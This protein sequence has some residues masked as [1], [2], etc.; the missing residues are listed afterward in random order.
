[1]SNETTALVER[2]AS[3]YRL[4]TTVVPEHYEIKLTPDLEKFTFAG[5]ETVRIKVLEPI[6]EIV[7]NAAELDIKHA[8][9]SDGSGKKVEASVSYDEKRERALLKLTESVAA[10]QYK[11]HID[12]SGIL[13]DKLHGFYRSSYKNDKGEIKLLAS[14]Q[15][16]AADARRAFPC[17]DEPDLKSVFK[18]TLTVDKQLTAISNAG[19]EKEEPAANGKKSIRFKES[20]KMSTYL[21]AFIVGEF[22]GTEPVKVGQ[23][24]I[25]V[26]SVPGKKH[27]AKFAVDAAVASLDFFEKYYGISYPGDKLDLIAIPDFASGAMENLGA[28]TFRENALLVDAKAA[29]HAELERIA[30]V[31]AHELAHMWFGDLVTMKWWNGLWLNEAFA[32]FMEMLAVDAWKPEWKRWETFGVSRAAAFSTDGLRST[33]TIEFP[34]RHPEEAGGMFDI[35]T[36]EKGASVLRMLEQYLGT[37]EFRKGIALYLK[38]HQYANAETTDLWD[39]LEESTKQPVRQ[40]MD[41]WIFQEGH[42]LVSVALNQEGTGIELSQVRFTYLQEGAAS[43]T[44][45][46]IPVLIR[47]KTTAGV[48]TKKLILDKESARVDLGGKVDWVVVNE[49]GHGFYRVRY[50]EELLTRLTADLWS[51][52]SAIERFNLVSDTWASTVAGHVTLPEYLKM[53]QMF[54]E[55]TDKNVWAIL[56]GSLHYMSKVIDSADRPALEA[57]ARRLLGNQKERLG[58]TPKSGED[59]LT[60]QLR[61]MILGAVGTLGNEAG[62]Q[63]QAKE[64]YARYKNDRSAAD[65]N[66]APAL[67]SILAYTGD[68]KQYDDFVNE[69]RSAKTPQEEQRYLFSLANFRQADLLKLTLDRTISGEVRTQNAPY[70]VQSVLANTFGRE[71]AW[72][73]L[74]K[75]WDEMVKLYPENSLPRMCEGVTNLVSAKLE[76]E[77]QQFFIDHKVRQGGK[78]IEQHLEKLRVAVLFKERESKRA[79][80]A[81]A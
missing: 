3:E 13:N 56:I 23:T 38:K 45:F 81:L 2:D 19:I 53:V 59:E 24:P 50:S 77:V 30:D 61:G 71:L 51:N 57:F 69:F 47:A 17:W 52:L 44:L 68:A 49:G 55:E 48:I 35:L 28:V 41:S 66:V 76:Q 26:W 1:M 31:V 4:P 16:E 63:A 15:F 80:G 67:V 46:H 33:R 73:F 14:T 64:L 18:V 78:T 40:M 12:F 32:T 72:E 42:P 21:V 25:R 20:M 75:N 6:S 39:A 54:I 11:L 5:E 22:E 43:K 74:K 65:P 79:A 37:E 9:V 29:S 58:W 36:Y 70:L 60:K 10:G 27:L 7:L 62:T 34:V 8:C